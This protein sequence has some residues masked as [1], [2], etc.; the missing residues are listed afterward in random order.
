MDNKYSKLYITSTESPIIAAFEFPDTIKGQWAYAK[1]RECYGLFFQL[2]LTCAMIYISP[3]MVV[4]F[5]IAMMSE[6][7]FLMYVAMVPIGLEGC[8]F[9]LTWLTK[10]LAACEIDSLLNI[11]DV[12]YKRGIIGAPTIRSDYNKFL[13]DNGFRKKGGE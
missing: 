5:L 2:F 1:Y 4:V 9:L 6:S 7:D 8:I 13:S 10:N 12:A 3:I 11:V